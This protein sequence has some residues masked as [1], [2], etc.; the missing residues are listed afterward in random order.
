MSLN[1]NSS[2]IRNWKRAL[3]L[4]LKNYVAFD[5]DPTNL[6]G[7]RQCTNAQGRNT[8][9]ACRE[10]GGRRSEMQDIVGA[11]ADG[12]EDWLTESLGVAL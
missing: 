11:T 10:C 9:S 5:S 1:R 12:R 4:A 8:C 3:I 7:N 6:A 2:Q